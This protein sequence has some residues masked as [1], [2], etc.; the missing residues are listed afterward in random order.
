MTRPKKYISKI[1]T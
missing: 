1:S